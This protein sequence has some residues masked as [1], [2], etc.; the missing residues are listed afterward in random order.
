MNR[1]SPALFSEASTAWVRASWPE[2][3][4]LVAIDGKP[5]AGPS[6]APM[7]PRRCIWSSPSP[8]RAALCSGRSRSRARPTNCR[9]SPS[10]SIDWRKAAGSRARWSRSTA[11]APTPGSRRRSRTPAADYLLADEANQPTPRAEAERLFAS[12]DPESLD[13][14]DSYDKGYGRIER[15]AAKSASCGKPIGS[16]ARGA[17]PER[18]ACPTRPCSF[19]CVRARSL[20][21]A[22]PH[23]DALL[24]LLGRAKSPQGGRGHARPLAHREPASSGS[25]S[26]FSPTTSP[27]WAKATAQKTWRSSG[28]PPSTSSEARPSPKD[29]RP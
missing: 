9:R 14:D 23:G 26:G 3:P 22:E 17:F 13:I 27:P 16:P 11:S 1:I 29:R 2:R 19:A 5:R 24:R 8:P 25:G 18:S 4:E 12:V 6:T 10:S 21:T 15:R 7:A 20:P 28:I